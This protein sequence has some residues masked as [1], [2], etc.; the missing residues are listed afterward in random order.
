MSL[1]ALTLL[2]CGNP[3]RT[4]AYEAWCTLNVPRTPPPAVY[5]AMDRQEKED[6]RNHNEFGK[7]H[8]GW[9]PGQ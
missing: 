8:C 5:A 7:R 9:E 6:M 3:D 4:G 1:I 2:G